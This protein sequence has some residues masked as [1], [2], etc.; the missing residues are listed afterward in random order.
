VISAGPTQ[1]ERID[2][3]A[4]R[5][6]IEQNHFSGKRQLPGEIVETLAVKPK[7]L[8]RKS[9]VERIIGKLLNL[10]ATVDDGM[11]SVW[12][13]CPYHTCCV[14]SPDRGGERVQAFS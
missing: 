6:M 10:V 12:D 7:S 13:Q 11:G 5:T 14:H 9:V 2:S 8:E 1:I 3:L 4:F